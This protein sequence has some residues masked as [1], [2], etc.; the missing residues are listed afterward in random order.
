MTRDPRNT[1]AYNKCLEL[2][3]KNGGR[4]VASI[5][6]RMR[7]L[8]YTRFNRR[9]LYGR[10]EEGTYKPGWID[11]YGW[12]ATLRQQQEEPPA[13]AGGSVLSEPGAV[14]TG[15]SS[16]TEVRSRREDLIQ[17]STLTG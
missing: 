4:D 5:E 16:A 10:Y 11:K 2:F 7:A 1:A 13:S 3:L 14:A 6:R 15:F 9:I 17:P 12:K 8:G